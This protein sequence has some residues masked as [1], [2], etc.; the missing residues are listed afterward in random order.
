MVLAMGIVAIMDKL[1]LLDGNNNDRSDNYEG[2]KEKTMEIKMICRIIYVALN[3][4]GIGIVIAK[5][6]DPHPPYSMVSTL[7][8]TAITFGLVFGMGAFTD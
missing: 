7:I 8:A 6:G 5:D 2:R 4:I 1:H 3:C